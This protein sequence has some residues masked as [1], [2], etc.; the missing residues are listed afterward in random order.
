VN[1]VTS[2]SSQVTRHILLCG[3]IFNAG[4]PHAPLHLGKRIGEQYMRNNRGN[5]IIS[6]LFYSECWCASFADG[7]VSFSRILLCVNNSSR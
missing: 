6:V 1:P 4:A 7:K 3:E 5:R 2:N